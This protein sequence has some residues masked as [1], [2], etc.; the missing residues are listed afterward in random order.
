MS[1]RFVIWF[2]DYMPEHRPRVGGKN[3]GL[4]EMI[5]ADLPVP[6]GFAVTTDGFETIRNHPEAIEAIRALLAKVDFD[7]PSGIR[8][9]SKD[10]RTRIEALPMD[11]EVEEAIRSAYAELC[12]RCNQEDVPV[13]V[14]SSATAEDLPDASFAGQQDTFLWVRGGASVVEHVQRC[15]S[16]L[17]TGRAMSY[18]HAMDHDHEVVSMSVVV[19]QM[20]DP[21]SAGVAFTLDPAT[22]DRS[23]VAIES[24]WG[25][26]EAVVSGEVTPDNFL[27]D[28]VILEI[29]SRTIS[30]KHT[31]LVM[32]SDGSGVQWR[33]VGEDRQGSPSV[34]DPELLEITR[35]AK[36]VERYFGAPQDIEWA[37]D[38]HLPEGRNVVMLQSRPETVWSRR[39][40]RQVSQPASGFMDSIVTT[41]LSPIHTR[42]ATTADDGEE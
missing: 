17:F 16:S 33:E 3:A 23:Q 31:E 4:G 40:P 8:G 14:R 2:E 25:L 39:A 20:V 21:K 34:T 1:N 32:A 28:K 12:R 29:H 27:V 38:R 35:M 37:V 24:S 9:I 13:A 26:G 18:R 42:G 6:P 15:W 41:L 19:Q 7:D 22:G 36:A 30:P 10:I 5:K 11:A